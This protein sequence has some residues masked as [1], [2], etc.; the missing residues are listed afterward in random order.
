MD[1]T[2]LETM[3]A[4]LQELRDIREINDL[5][6]KWHHA[7]TGGWSGKQAGGM[8]ALE[9]LSEDA[10]I[11]IE[12]HHLPGEGPKGPKECTEFWSFFYGDE[13]PLPYVFQC[14]VSE[15]VTVNGDTAV[16]ESVQYCVLQ[17]RDQ[18]PRSGVVQRVNN[19][20]RTPASWRIQ[21]VMHFGGYF[22]EVEKLIGELNP[23][24]PMDQ[25]K[26]WTYKG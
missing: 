12:G 10:T 14:S 13:G 5:W 20:V 25:R 24:R 3:K 23:P 4:H 15:R 6:F 19:M 1:Q 2:E 8:E 26:P 17:F 18:K 21:K 16:Q 22:F 11:E 9:C 7:C